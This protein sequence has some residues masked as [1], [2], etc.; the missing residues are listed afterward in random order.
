MHRRDLLDMLRRHQPLDTGEA[1]SL[2]RIEAF[3]RSHSDCFQRSLQI[4]HITGSAWIVNSEGTHALFTHHRKLGMWLQLGGHADG[5]SDVLAVALS[6][7]REESGIDRII[8]VSKDIFDVDVHAIPARHG[9]AAHD[10]YDIRF[11]LTTSGDEELRISDESLDLRWV[12]MDDVERLGVDASV[13]R[14]HAKWLEY[15]RAGR[16][17]RTTPAVD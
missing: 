14:M 6:E 13:R 4:G 3:V 7:A 11:L 5:N 2:V 12:A 15:H 16:W 10:H 9:E 1:E 17:R 8:P